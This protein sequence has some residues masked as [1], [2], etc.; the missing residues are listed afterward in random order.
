M[1]DLVQAVEEAGIAVEDIVAAPIAAS[2]VALSKMQKRVGCVL[3]NI[4][5]ETLS[6]IVFEDAVP[7]SVK[8]FAVGGTDITN[9]LALSLR[10]PPEE[11]EQLKH[12]AILGTPYP[13]RKV[14]DVAAKRMTEMFKLVEAHL[15]KIGKNELLPA[16]VILTGGSSALQSAADLA[17]AVLRL[18]SRLAESHGPQRMQLQDSTWTVAYGLTIWGLTSGGDLEGNN[19]SDW[20]D[21]LRSLWR[22]L[23]KFLP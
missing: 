5:A 18:P 13:K 21:P 3:A 4:G 22:W 11:A 10:I 20:L 2:F 15:K 6:L 9:D 8:V 23:K 16:G 19:S 12:G 14:E 17:K 1:G 7:M